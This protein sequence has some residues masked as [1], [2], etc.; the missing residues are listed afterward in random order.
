M[1]ELKLRL[2]N[3]KNYYCDN[4]IINAILV[5]KI[6]E[7]KDKN[8]SIKL[9]I[10]I[11][12]EPIISNSEIISLLTNLID[13]SI[14]AVIHTNDSKIALDI[15]SIDSFDVVIKNA[16]NENIKIQK[17]NPHLHGYGTKIIKDITHKYKGNILVQKYNGYYL[18]HISIPNKYEG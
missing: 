17:E 13:N 16:Y 8:L 15:I 2:S 12:N 7:A 9:N 14:E 4:K 10:Q 1:I 5:T 3:T 11:D 18:T 6:K